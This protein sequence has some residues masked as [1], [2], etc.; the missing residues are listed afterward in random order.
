LSAAPQNTDK[1]PADKGLEEVALL[2]A[3][4]RFK[5]LK[6]VMPG[7]ELRIEAKKLTEVGKLVCIGGTVSVGGEMVANGELTVVS[8]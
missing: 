1:S 5:F 6:P 4:N 7:Q 3:I 8:A 2:A